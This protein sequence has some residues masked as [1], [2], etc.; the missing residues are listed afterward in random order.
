MKINRI[1][2][3]VAVAVSVVFVSGYYAVCQAAQPVKIKKEIP[4]VNA[5]NTL[6][7]KHPVKIIS[8]KTGTTTKVPRKGGGPW[9]WTAVVANTGSVTIKKGKIKFEATT[10]TPS[11]KQYV[12]SSVILNKDIAPGS[13]ATISGRWSNCNA[14]KLRLKITSFP[15]AGRSALATQTTSVQ[16]ISAQ[17]QNFT[18]IRDTKTWTAIIK[19]T[20]RVPL[21]FHTTGVGTRGQTSE[22]ITMQ[23]TR[24]IPPGK[25]ITLTGRY[26]L[27]QPG[28]A[29]EY[30][31]QNKCR[32]CSSC[33][34]TIMT[35]DT[36]K[37]TY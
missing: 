21:S 24:V 28:T 12:V 11:G 33:G 3:I 23:E 1:M 32:Y 5:T 27:W 35:L 4:K 16:Q 29:I 25:T 17:I 30:M 34:E 8:L 7:S 14:K 13:K 9:Y 26:N 20:S 18:F 37:Y 10:I 2:S 22:C 15:I 19:N 36:F 31:V 6:Q